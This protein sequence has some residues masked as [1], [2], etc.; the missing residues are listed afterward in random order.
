MLYANLNGD[1]ILPIPKT[2]AKCPLCKEKVISKCG[3]VKVWHWAHSKGGSCDSWYEPET[4]WHKNWKLTFGK[5][6]C[7]IRINKEARWHVADVFTKDGVVIELQ[8]SPIQ[9]DVI[10][11]REDFY[12][13]K[14]IWVI[15]GVKFKDHFYLKDLGEKYNHWTLQPAK[16]MPSF[17]KVL[18][19]WE[20]ARRSWED[21]QR[22]IFIDFQD[23]S[24][25]WV[26]SGMGSTFGEGKFVS[27]E[28]FISKYGG[29]YNT[30]INL[31]NTRTLTFA[32]K[33][34]IQRTLKWKNNYIITSYR[35]DG[36]PR[37]LE[38]HFEN[39]NDINK[40]S[41]FRVFQV[42]GILKDQESHG[43]LK[44]EISKLIGS[45]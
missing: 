32:R 37:T 11:K 44:I 19:K 17:E 8:N 3:D 23:G 13:D 36:K 33:Q 9:K 38:L 41:E 7:E 43:N 15:N 21:C 16:Y 26:H 14:M 30:Y 2:E 27:K 39:H 22:H 6:N 18:F 10:R 1:K 4:V 29:D 42:T 31:V 20:F 35:Y 34:I 25:F 12:G 45:K 28:K 24:L 5:E 40:V